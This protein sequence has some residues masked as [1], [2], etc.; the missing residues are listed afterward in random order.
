M[1]NI[2]CFEKYIGSRNEIKLLKIER[3]YN[4][5]NEIKKKTL[6]SFNL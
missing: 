3:R 1:K 2:F 4:F 6:K 5:T